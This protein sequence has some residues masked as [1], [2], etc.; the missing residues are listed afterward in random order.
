MRALVVHV[1]ARDFE[2][3]VVPVPAFGDDEVY[4]IFQTVTYSGIC[5]TDQ[6]IHEGEF[7][8]IQLIPGHEGVGYV[9]ATGKNVKDFKI[10]DL[11]AG[12]L[13]YSAAIAFTADRT[14]PVTA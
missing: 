2:V 7:G 14:R 13:N 5:G 8:Q 6:H 9:A 10:G 11:V 1:K 4:S 12:F 3:R